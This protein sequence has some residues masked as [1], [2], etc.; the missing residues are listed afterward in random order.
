MASAG[1]AVDPSVRG[2][3]ICWVVKDDDAYVDRA[4]TLLVGGHEANEKPVA[5]GPQDSAAL[6]ALAGTVDIAADPRVAFLGGGPLDTEVM[7]AMFDE[8]SELAR[9]EG[10][11]GVRVV[12][13]MDWLLPMA[14]DAADVV[15][16]ELELD[17][18]IQRLGA[19]VVCA[20]RASSFDAAVLEGSLCVHPVGIGGGMDPQ[21][22]LVA[23]VEQDW[24]VSGEIDFSC[25]A[26]FHA[27][28][29]TAL[30]SAPCRIEASD[31]RFVDVAGLRQ[32]ALA[33]RSSE[34]SVTIVGAPRVVRR[35]WEAAGF[36]EVAP[37][38][39]FLV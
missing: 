30:T 38:V 4:T 31:L 1:S 15:A 28:L 7:L 14:P 26:A 19:T 24:R 2:D 36:D 10:Y 35:C 23:S 37:H 16:F 11:D 17:R 5:F 25:T 9:R 3:H 39:E 34:A 12:A 18:Q 29:A 27:A 21:F 6:H 32:L 8:Q 33:A 20:Y 13:D 22:Q